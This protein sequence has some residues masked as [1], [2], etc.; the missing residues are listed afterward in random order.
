MIAKVEPLTQS[1]A[2]RG[3]FDYRVPDSM[4]AGVGSVLVVPFGRRRVLGVVVETAERSEV[5]AEKLVEPIEAL[6]GGVPPD[7]VRLGLWTAEEYVST[8]ARGLSLVLPPGTGTGARQR[9]R[10]RRALRAEL[11][12]AGREALDGDARLGTKQREALERLAGG[13]VPAADLGHGSLRRL[14]ARGLVALADARVERRPEIRALGAR[15]PVGQLTPA[16]VAAVEHI[17]RAFASGGASLLLH[18][19]TG[20]GK[21]EVYLRAAAAALDRGR[22]VIVLVPEIGLT[23]QTAARFEQRFGDQVAV[24]HSKL[25]ARER[26]DEWMRMRRGDARVCV[27]P[28]SAVFAPLADVGLIVVDEEHDPSYKQE[29][30]PRYDARRVAARRAEQAGAVLVAG[31]A[32]PRPESFEELERIVLPE[33]VDG[34][35]LPPVEV[36]GMLDAPGPL[37]PRT[38][39]ALER[40]RREQQKAIVL[41]NRRGWSNFLSCGVCGRVWRCPQCDVS[42]VLHRA[43]GAVA[44]HHCGHREPVPGTCPDCGS[45]AVS[46]HGLGT[47]RLE[48]ELVDLMDPLPVVRLDADVAK[49]EATLRSFDE[50]P[51][52]VL[53]GTQMVAKGHDFPDVTLGVVVDADST[54]RFPDFRAEERT[55]A[56]VAQLAGRSGRGARGGRVIVQTADPAAECLR[57]AAAHDADSFLAEELA[58]RRLLSYPPFA[59]LIRVVCSAEEPGPE[60]EAAEAIKLA[61]EGLPVLGP[62][63]LFR[64]KGRERAQLVVKASERAPAVRSVR[65]AV[66]AVVAE[67][68]GT[69]VNF[70]VDVDPQ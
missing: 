60:V 68:A 64:L 32:T 48:R 39:D 47:E 45:T 29:G 40:V 17:E 34:R 51:A 55:F 61:L 21:T 22:S 26:F 43:A 46:R 4:D 31:S 50:A 42:L 36:V 6:E 3:P 8:P 54:L 69:G 25:S 53:V 67:R 20:S 28:R 10:T 56:L 12:A 14:E 24:I 11:T 70:A 52:G 49:V 62:A 35:G 59:T 23:P 37:H 66:E 30:D 5:P 63:P 27:G 58:R 9:T 44:C 1:R 2:L 65:R 7:L 18:G 19:V 33:R 38:R 57:H 41:L 16:Q 15:G 13:A